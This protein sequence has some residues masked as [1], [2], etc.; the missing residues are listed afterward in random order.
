MFIYV[1][2]RACTRTHLIYGRWC[3]Y[4]ICLLIYHSSSLSKTTDNYP[5]KHAGSDSHMV[6]IGWEA[7]ARTER[8]GWFWHTGLLPDRIDLAKTWH[9]PPE[10]NHPD[11]SWFCTICSG[12]SVEDCNR[13]WK[14]KTGS[15]GPVVFCQKPRPPDDSC[16]P[17][18][19]RTR[20]V[21]P[22][23]WPGDPDLTRAGFTQYDQ[24]FFGRTEPNR[25]REVGPGIYTQ[26]GPI[27]AA[28][29]P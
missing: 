21:W 19:F 3:A 18:C 6:R 5:S 1:S 20:Y 13:V 12:P 22:E 14:W 29:W 8:V 9:S 24:A 10:L 15:G 4:Q 28:R 16:S 2:E 25:T 7:L 17:A 26:S 27:L 23:T 11:P